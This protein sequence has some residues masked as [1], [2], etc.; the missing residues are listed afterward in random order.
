MTEI[1]KESLL[2][3]RI[4]IKK[5]NESLDEAI[6]NSGGTPSENE[7]DRLNNFS[8][9]IYENKLQKQNNKIQ[10][11]EEEIQRLKNVI[12]PLEEDSNWLNCL[13]NAGVDN[14]EGYDIAIDAFNEE[15]GEDN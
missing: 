13:R 12:I 10:N 14:W 4:Y 9:A 6:E 3:V 2:I 8:I 11:L 7:L 15:Y 1:Q 5:D